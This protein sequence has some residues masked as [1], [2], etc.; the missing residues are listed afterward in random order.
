LD[1]ALTNL[2]DLRYRYH[3]S[4]VDA[5]GFGGTATLSAEY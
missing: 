2:L 3:G 4:G 5:P 1:V